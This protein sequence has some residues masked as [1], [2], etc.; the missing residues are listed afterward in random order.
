MLAMI[1]SSCK[2]NKTLAVTLTVRGGQHSVPVYWRRSDQRSD[3]VMEATGSRPLRSANEREVGVKP[4][5]Y[6]YM[7]SMTKL[8]YQP[9]TIDIQPNPALALR[10]IT[11]PAKKRLSI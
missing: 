7:R 8:D 3:L 4:L 9:A 6:S 1:H 11:A 5:R 10:R 2:L